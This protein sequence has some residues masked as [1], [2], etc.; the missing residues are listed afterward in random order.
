VFL[1]APLEAAQ[2][3]PPAA[4]FWPWLLLPALVVGVFLLH[5]WLRDR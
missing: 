5:Q 2:G 1:E 3:L 4:R